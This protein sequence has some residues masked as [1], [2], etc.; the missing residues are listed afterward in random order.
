MCFISG[1]LVHLQRIKDRIRKYYNEEFIDYI[2]GMEQRKGV[3]IKMISTIRLLCESIARC[4]KILTQVGNSA[5][6]I[7]EDRRNSKRSNQ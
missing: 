3:E 2:V 4:S 7:I 5:G 1:F 6:S